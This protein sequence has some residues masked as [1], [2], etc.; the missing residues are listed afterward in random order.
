[1]P[2]IQFASNDQPS[3]GTAS[4]RSL[5]ASP[6][7]RILGD[8]TDPQ[9]GCLSGLLSRGAGCPAFPGIGMLKAVV[10][11][12]N[13]V[14]EAHRAFYVEKNGKFFLNVTPAEGYEL[15]DVKGLKTALGAE[16]NNVAVLKEQLKPYEGLDAGA[17][18]TAIERVSA[19][20]EITP[21]AAR[22]AVETAERLSK[23]DPAKEADRI[24][25]EKFETLKGQ[26]TAQWTLRE[27]ELSTQVKNANATV[28]SL[29]GQLQT[30][31]ADSQIKSEVAKANPLDDARDAVELL[32]SKFVKT[33][34]KDGQVSVQVLDTNGNPRIKDVNGTPFTVADLVAEIR[35]SRA[36]LFK[37]EEKRGLGTQPG[38]H[39]N[40]PAGGG[41]TNP[42]MKD[43]WNMT[44]QM[45][46]SN[47]KPELAKQ[48]KAAAGVK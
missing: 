9:A 33:S 17:A 19:F 5:L 35:E 8:I 32:V 48:L 1:M 18:R 7:P 16:R 36:S 2:A 12:I 10:T 30:I 29:T 41:Q 4:E 39:G 22:T 34:M 43:T 42:W 31:M 37:P 11:D 21:D 38:T 3:A 24:A 27:T 20:G 28:E 44:Q 46:L 13:T 15:D 23:L 40:P 45:L 47:Q 14:D 25:G 26:L 6:I